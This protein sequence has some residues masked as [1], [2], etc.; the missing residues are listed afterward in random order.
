MTQFGKSSSAKRSK[1]SY[2]YAI[3]GVAL[4]LFLFG[5][6]GWMSLNLKKWGEVLKEQLQVNAYIL[7]SATQK[8]KDSV[9]QFV[10]SLPYVRNAEYI[11]KDKAIAS[12]NLE[13]DSSWKKMIDYNPLPESVSFFLNS[14]YVNK[15]SLDNLRNLLLTNYGH[16]I[17]EFQDPQKTIQ[18]VGSFVKYATIFVFIFAVIGTIIVIVSIDNT[19]RL[20]MYS[21]RFI[22][23]TMQMVGATRGF[24]SR[25]LNVK[26]VINGTIA[27]LI[28]IVAM[29]AFMLFA[30]SVVPWL[31]QLRDVTN[32]AIVVA[33]MLILG[34]TISWVST[35]RAVIKYLKIKL[36]DLY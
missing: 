14:N 9:F 6:V 29:I 10:T 35:H 36:D 12:Y 19:I 17:S 26:A 8:Q 31:K 27:A 16:V 22:I 7:P 1:P 25:P 4:I 11:T 32:L 34:I 21:N 5:I 28:A 18:N 33:G 30:E 2:A 15:D 3:I 23:K 13:N 20:A 24:I